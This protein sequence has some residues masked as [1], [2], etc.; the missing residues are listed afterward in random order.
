MVVVTPT[1]I[2]L[3]ASMGV[4]TRT[5]HNPRSSFPKSPLMIKSKTHVQLKAAMRP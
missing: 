2:V 4:F 5:P 1:T 3:P